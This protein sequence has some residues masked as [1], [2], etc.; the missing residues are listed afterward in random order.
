VLCSIP[1]NRYVLNQITSYAEAVPSGLAHAIWTELQD[2]QYK[3]NHEILQVAAS[4]TTVPTLVLP[5]L[6]KINLSGGKTAWT[7]MNAVAQRVQINFLRVLVNKN[8]GTGTEWRLAAQTQISCGPIDHLEPDALGQL[9]N[10]FRLRNRAGIDAAARL[11][12]GSAGSS[13]DLSLTAAPKENSTNTHPML[14]VSNVLGQDSVDATRTIQLV[15]DATVGQISLIQKKTSDGSTYTTGIIA[16]EYSGNGAPSSST[17]PANTYY[18]KGDKYWDES[19]SP[20]D[21]W[22][23]NTDGTNATSSWDNISGCSP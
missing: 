1:T 4:T 7:T 21:F 20:P 18:R 15:G 23:C 12:G 2:L 13:S 8:D 17:L 6:H 22:R 5:G 16:P 19:V 10:V 14:A 3:L 11:S 9:A